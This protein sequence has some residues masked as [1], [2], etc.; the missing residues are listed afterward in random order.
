VVT[1]WLFD[2]VVAAAA[3]RDKTALIVGAQRVRR[4]VV[5]GQ[6]IR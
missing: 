3:Q 6:R 1:R 2:C 4:D 5:D